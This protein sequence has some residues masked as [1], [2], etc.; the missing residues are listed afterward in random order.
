MV[1][2]TFTIRSTPSD[3]CYG[4]QSVNRL[5]RQ[6][7]KSPVI[8]SSLAPTVLRDILN[9]DVNKIHQGRPN[10]GI[11][12]WLLGKISSDPSFYDSSDKPKL[13]PIYVQPG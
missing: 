3:I 11:F 5:S 1:I 9:I 12:R 7:I 8:P 4:W 6:G 2:A 13:D 10:S